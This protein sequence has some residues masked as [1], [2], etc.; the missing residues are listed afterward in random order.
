MAKV[1]KTWQEISALLQ[2]D[3][4][5]IVYGY[6]FILP[7]LLFHPLDIL[8][9]TSIQVFSVS[10]PTPTLTLLGI[11]MSIVKIFLVNVR[12]ASMVIVNTGGNDVL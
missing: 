7:P 6:L 11:P 4:E 10:T 5:P 3:L 12:G 9:P 8:F 2:A 1:D